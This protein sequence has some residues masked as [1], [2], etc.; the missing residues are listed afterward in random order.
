MKIDFTTGHKQ[1][2]IMDL[3]GSAGSVVA[4]DFTGS[5]FDCAR[6]LLQNDASGASIVGVFPAID[7][8]LI[9]LRLDLLSAIRLSGTT[10]G[11]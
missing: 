11:P 9:G 2:G 8:P 5:P 4:F 10:P 3:Q 1:G 7:A 6:F